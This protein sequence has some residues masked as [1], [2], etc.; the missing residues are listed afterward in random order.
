MK[1]KQSMKKQIKYKPKSLFCRECIAGIGSTTGRFSLDMIKAFFDK[2]QEV[3]FNKKLI[4][5]GKA[6][7]TLAR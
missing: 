2:H 7:S 1:D 6:L 5:R 3:Y 4:E